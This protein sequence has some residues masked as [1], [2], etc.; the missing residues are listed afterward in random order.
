[1]LQLFQASSTFAGTGLLMNFGNTTGSFSASTSK[2]VDL[3]NAGTSRFSISAYGTTTIGDGTTNYQAGLQIG[4]GGLCVDNDGA[5]S[6][7]TTGRVTSVSSA[8]GNSDLAEM[9]FSSETLLPGEIV[10]AKGD[11]SVGRASGATRDRVIGV[12]STKPGLTLGFDD[13]SLTVGER[14]YP[15]ALTGRVPIRLS[16]ENGP[17]KV[18]DELM[19]SSIPG[20][21]MRA[22]STGLIVG[23]ALED[24][25]TTRAYS[26]TYVNQFGDDIIEPVFAAINPVA[27]PRVSDGCYFGGGNATGEEVCVP[28]KAT[29][30]DGKLAEAAELAAKA[31]RT[32]AL[33]A[34]ARTGSEQMETP[35]RESVQVGQIV[36]LVD[37][38]YRY[39]DESSQIMIADLLATPVAAVNE[40]V[41]DTVWSRLVTLAN[42]FVDGVLSVFTLRADRVEVKDELCVDGVCVNALDLQKMLEQN[43]KPLQSVETGISNPNDSVSVK[44]TAPAVSSV[45]PDPVSVVGEVPANT[46]SASDNQPLPLTVDTASTSVSVETNTSVENSEPETELLDNEEAPVPVSIQSSLEES[47]PVVSE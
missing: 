27:D 5:C 18:G 45:V 1:M 13:T 36:M 35:T 39:L 22:S 47:V 21:A 4:F 44:P 40:S 7:S 26:D 25:D 8:T 37:L 17:V 38:R 11:L 46:A 10:F 6:A 34:L 16:N 33:K 14:G 32:A 29:T 9:Y 41:G 28:L 3:Q 42:Q 23:V 19:L 15:L 30:T 12:V 31:A 20:V 24:F 43:N 2:F